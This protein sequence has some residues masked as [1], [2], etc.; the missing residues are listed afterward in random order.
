MLARVTPGFV[1]F[2][3]AHLGSLLLVVAMAAGLGPLARRRPRVDAIARPALAGSAVIAE[4]VRQA[5][6]LSRGAWRADHDLPVHLCALCALLVPPLLYG[7]SPRLFAV[8]YCWSLAAPLQALLT[9]DITDGFPSVRFVRFMVTHGVPVVAVFYAAAVDGHRPGLRAVPLALGATAAYAALLT[10]INLALDAN[11]MF[12]RAKPATAS[13]FDHLGPWPY[14]LLGI[15]A[16][17]A[18]VMFLSV[19]PW[20]LLARRAR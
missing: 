1:L 20:V 11:Y 14:Y 13:V 2:G 15:Y 6:L 3:P 4:I 10:P 7:R 16:F 5:D 8:L 18:V 9:P 19:L 12:L 17:G